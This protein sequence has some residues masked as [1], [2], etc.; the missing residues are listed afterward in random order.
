MLKLMLHDTTTSKQIA[1]KEAFNTPSPVDAIPPNDWRQVQ[2]DYPRSLTELVQRCTR[3]E[4]RDRISAEELF[5]Q[6]QQH[7]RERDK[8][9][10]NSVPMYLRPLPDTT[11][12]LFKTDMY[13]RLARQPAD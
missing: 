2:V 5:E 11:P 6:I 13:T 3:G 8:S 9:D 4:V 7:T 10:V 1:L 12:L